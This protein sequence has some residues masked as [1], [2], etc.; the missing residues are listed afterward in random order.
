[1]INQHCKRLYGFIFTITNKRIQ[2]PCF[3]IKFSDNK[4]C[5]DRKIS[6]GITIFRQVI[7]FWGFIN[8]LSGFIV[9]AL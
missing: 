3:S 2:W 9:M 5:P 1:M 7:S 4:F 8:Q 6:S